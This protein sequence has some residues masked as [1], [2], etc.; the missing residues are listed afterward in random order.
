MAF[1]VRVD[2]RISSYITALSEWQTTMPWRGST[3]DNVRPLDSRKKKHMTI[4]KLNDES[5]ALSLYN[6][7]VVVYHPDDSITFTPHQSIS[8]DVFA[9]ALTPNGI[10]THFNDSLGYIVRMK[11]GPSNHEN[12]YASYRFYMF[13]GR[14]TLKRIGQNPTFP[15]EYF[16]AIDERTTTQI[17][18]KRYKVDRKRAKIASEKYNVKGFE[19][20]F[21]AMR[22][23]DMFKGHRKDN[24]F[25]NDREMGALILSD[26][27]DKWPEF[28]KHVY[29]DEAPRQFKELAYRLEKVGYTEE[30]MELTDW[31]EWRSVAQSK[32]RNWRYV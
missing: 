15:N 30:V 21:N 8:T 25:W 19:N 4:R 32:S 11:T 3:D 6:T 31:D 10:S 27:E 29:L 1:H 16:W 13:S 14:F 17:P 7:D 26:R 24:F 2:T 5:I 22:A 9:R 28:M 12:P 20:W 23:L 18:F